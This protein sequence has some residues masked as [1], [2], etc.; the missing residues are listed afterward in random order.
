MKQCWMKKF[1]FSLLSTLVQNKKIF[2]NES[3]TLML[4]GRGCRC[5]LLRLSE[6]PHMSWDNSM[7]L[8]SYNGEDTG[9]C[10]TW[11]YEISDVTSWS[12]QKI[13][14]VFK[15]CPGKTEKTEWKALIAFPGNTVSQWHR[16]VICRSITFKRPCILP[17]S[18]T[19]SF[20]QSQ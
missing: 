18:L 11:W 5:N 2:Q 3:S 15:L 6:Y 20:V 17:H 9:I 10:W 12:T 8:L 19:C 7:T 16:K 4:L 14:A 1:C 13:C